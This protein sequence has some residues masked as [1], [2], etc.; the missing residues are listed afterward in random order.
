[1]NVWLWQF[2]ICTARL[3][4]LELDAGRPLVAQPILP[5]RT[6]VHALIPAKLPDRN[7][8]ASI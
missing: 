6:T 5:A 4:V 3:P 7:L 2:V 8:R 1:V